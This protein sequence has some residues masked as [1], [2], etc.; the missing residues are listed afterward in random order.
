METGVFGYAISTFFEI[1]R[2]QRFACNYEFRDVEGKVT[3]TIIR[4]LLLLG[5]MASF[6][7]ILRSL[8]VPILRSVLYL[9]W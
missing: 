9:S 2:M 8:A 6:P 3:P 4:K 1:S 5:K 7:I